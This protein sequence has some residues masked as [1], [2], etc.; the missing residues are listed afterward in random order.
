M[1]T[2]WS[3]MLLTHTH[4]HIH[5]HTPPYPDFIGGSA[6]VRQ[7]PPALSTDAHINLCLGSKV[8]IL[9]RSDRQNFLGGCD[10]QK[11]GYSFDHHWSKCLILHPPWVW[12][13]FCIVCVCVCVCVSVCE[14]VSEC[15]NVQTYQEVHPYHHAFITKQKTKIPQIHLKMLDNTFL[16]LTLID[17]GGVI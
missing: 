4:T 17:V 8:H 6:V 14:R 5:T 9:A 3:I 11:F 15:V 1:I 7:H 10:L 12:R 16:P 2:E 13:T